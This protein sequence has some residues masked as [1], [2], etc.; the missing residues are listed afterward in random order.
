MSRSAAFQSLSSRPSLT[1]VQ[2]VT[3]DLHAAWTLQI[4][5]RPKPILDLVEMTDAIPRILWVSGHGDRAPG[6]HHPRAS[7]DTPD[8]CH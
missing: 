2:Q 6:D 7:R 4:P 3:I 1:W 8:Q 5:L